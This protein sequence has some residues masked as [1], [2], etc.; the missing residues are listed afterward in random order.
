MLVIDVL[1]VVWVGD[2]WPHWFNAGVLIALPLQVGLGAWW[3]LR[4]GKRT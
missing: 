1:A 2:D 4:G 3:A